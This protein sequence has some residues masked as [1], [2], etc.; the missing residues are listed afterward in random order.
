MIINKKIVPIFLIIFLS[1]CVTHKTNKTQDKAE[2]I[3][4]SSRGFALI[5][6]DGVSD[7][8]MN[9]EKDHAMHSSLKKNTPIKI[10]NPENSKFFE[11]KISKTSAYPKIFNIIITKNIAEILELDLNNPYVEVFEI[12]KNKKFIAR[13][14]NMF[15]EEKKVAEKA[16]VD[17]VQMDILSNVKSNKAKEPSLNKFILVISDFYYHETANNLKKKL[18]R[19]TQLKNLYIEKININKYRLAAGPFKNFNA[20]KSTYIS[21][22]NLGFEDLNINKE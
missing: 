15:D 10:I 9:I 12:K 8:K 6:E 16:P 14:S 22:N 17:D 7:K 2:K 4:F 5:Y 3:F 13:E 11:T 18:L 1:S 21:L 20:L 19:E